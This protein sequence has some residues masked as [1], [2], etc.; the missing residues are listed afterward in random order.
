MA[1]QT[2]FH[3]LSRQPW[4]VTLAVAFVVFWIAYGIFPPVAPF[5]ALPFVVLGAYIAFIQFRKGSPGNVDERLDEL[6]SLTWEAFSAAVTVAYRKQGYTVLPP[7]GA[8]Y[9]FK[10][11]R[12]GRTTLL[13]C[14]RWKV[15]QVGEGPVRE[16]AHAVERGDAARGICIAA[17]E[18]SA[19]ARKFAAGEPVTLVSGRDLTEL[20]RL[21]KKTRA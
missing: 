20:V 14:R 17:G 9:D 8:G 5:V 3:L 12:D 7:D 19:P 21:P 15:N 18:F 6:R 1:K 2:L 11:V 13:Q 16:L 10:L 4:W